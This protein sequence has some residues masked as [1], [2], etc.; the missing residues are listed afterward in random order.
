MSKAYVFNRYGGPESQEL[1]DRQVPEPG[2]DELGVEVHAAGVN[3]AD[4]KLRSGRLGQNQQL[5][6]AMGQEVAGIVTA[7]GVGVKNFAVGDKIL[8]LVAPSHGGYAERTIVR[9]TDAVP[10][11]EEI[12]FAN[13]ATIAVAGAAAYDGTH[14]IE[15]QAGQTVLILGVGGGAGLMAAQIGRVH[16]FTVIGPRKSPSA[17]SSNPREP[18]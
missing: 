6:V 13:A 7:I 4:W 17:T 2:P 5:P 10:K 18:C 1:I 15:L 12:S 11:P 16:E 8:G 3:P 14:Q 9:A